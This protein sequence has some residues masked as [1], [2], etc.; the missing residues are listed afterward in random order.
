MTPRQHTTQPR[1]EPTRT[2]VRLV[3]MSEAM[4]PLSR[5]KILP[6]HEPSWLER[7]L[8]RG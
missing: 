7:L 8:G 1:R 5:G 3:Q 6:M 2:G 4:R